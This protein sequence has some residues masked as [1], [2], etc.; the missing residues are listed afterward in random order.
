[1]SVV[2]DVVNLAAGL[3]APQAV[4][5]E[6]DAVSVVHKAVQDGVGVGG[7]GYGVMP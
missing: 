1:V 6:F 5:I 2:G 7:V 3:C 4:A